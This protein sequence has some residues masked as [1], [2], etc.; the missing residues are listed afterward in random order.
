MPDSGDEHEA[1]EAVQ[2][3]PLQHQPQPDVSKLAEQ[4]QLQPQQLPLQQLQVATHPQQLQQP[5]QYIPHIADALQ[6]TRKTLHTAS[7]Q[8]QAEQRLL[9]DQQQQHQRQ[10]RQ[11][12]QEQEQQ[13]ALDMKLQAAEAVN[14]AFCR[15]IYSTALQYLQEQC[16]TEDL[17]QQFLD[18][19]DRDD[20][21]DQP[22]SVAH[23]DINCSKNRYRDVVPYDHN[24][25]CLPLPLLP[26]QQHAGARSSNSQ[27]A[28]TAA[29]TAA[30]AAAA[31]KAALGLGCV[32]NNYINA[33]FMSDP[34]LS[35]DQAALQ[36]YIATQVGAC[37]IAS[38]AS[39]GCCAS[40]LC[41]QLYQH[42]HGITLL[43]V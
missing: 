2:Q 34:Q 37:S 6:P 43:S 5:Q 25:V 32:G 10:Q 31:G 29:A 21:F 7:Q 35:G 8:Q 22:C 4:L 40:V 23:Q 12:Q 11:Q 19:L 9:G 33:S 36:G 38:I 13:H 26:A 20:P 27:A 14:S 24:R 17:E 15:H 41:A 16:S 3:Q 28:A 42:S 30:A 18:I 39:S 1:V